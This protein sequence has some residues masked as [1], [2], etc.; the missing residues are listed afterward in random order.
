MQLTDLQNVRQ[1]GSYVCGNYESEKDGGHRNRNYPLQHGYTGTEVHAISF[2]GSKRTVNN[3]KIE[4][5]ASGC[6]DVYCTQL[7]PDNKI[8][9]GHIEINDLHAGAYLYG[10]ELPEEDPMPNK[11]P[12]A[13]DLNKTQIQQKTEKLFQK[14]RDW[15]K[16]DELHFSFFVFFFLWFSMLNCSCDWGNT[17]KK[18]DCNYIIYILVV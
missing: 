4:N 10:G 3:V 14:S 6:G 2:A 5:V 8:E 15:Y 16:W 11:I 18:F 9:I 7:F 1:L 12:R 17:W 13:N